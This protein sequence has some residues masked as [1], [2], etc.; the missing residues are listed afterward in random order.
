VDYYV[1][2][3]GTHAWPGGRRLAKFLD[4]PS[5]AIAATPLIWQF[6]AAHPKP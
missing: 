3:G 2:D 5:Q 4:E 6:F 1:I